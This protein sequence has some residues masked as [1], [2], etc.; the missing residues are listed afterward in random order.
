M[1]SRQW[2]V[3]VAVLLFVG[4]LL[5]GV[6]ATIIFGP[7]TEG[8][9]TPR[10]VYLP[11]DPSLDTAIDSLRRAGVL[12][13][14]GTFRLVA[15][16]TGWGAQLKSGHYRIAPRSS[17]YRMLDELRRGLQDPVR[18]R[19]PPGRRREG[20]ARVMGR[21]LE[22]DAAAFRAA[23]RDTSLARGL[24]TVPSRLFGYMLP[25]TYEFYWQTSPETVVRRVKNAF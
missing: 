4:G 2:F 17:N 11:P 13:N 12:A 6:G 9:D 3:L 24:G 25:E 8:Y 20:I 10:S 16:A 15:T 21:T 5:G 18:L 19:I 23:L 22:P 7:N 14:P 1:R